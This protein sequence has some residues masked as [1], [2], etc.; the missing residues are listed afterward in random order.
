M[1]PQPGEIPERVIVNLLTL[2]RVDDAATQ[3]LSLLY[4]EAYAAIREDG[5]YPAAEALSGVRE[6]LDQRTGSTEAWLV[7]QVITLFAQGIAVGRGHEHVQLEDVQLV[8]ENLCDKWPDC[9]IM[10]LNNV[11]QALGTIIEWHEQNG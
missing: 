1:I 3:E 10:R 5:K 7:F 8:R 9:T 6:A 2:E 4:R 11:S